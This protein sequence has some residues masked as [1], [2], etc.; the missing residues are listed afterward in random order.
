MTHT[1]QN[2]EKAYQAE[3]NATRRYE[4]FAAK[5]TEEKQLQ[6]AKLFRAISRSEAIHMKNH[7]AAIM[8]LGGKPGALVY[9]QVQVKTTRENLKEPI[10]GEKQ[11][12]EASYPQF[13]KT[14]RQEKAPAA[15]TTFTYALNAEAQH[16]KLLEEA[17]DHFGKNKKMDYYVSNVTGSTIAVIPGNAAPRPVQ[18]GEKFIKV[19]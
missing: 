17:L 4:Q 19:L 14:A 16:E 15:V 6:I 3:A 18:K 2:L 9:E 12:T 1:L 13:V 10:E 8:K 5:A 7:K 11:E